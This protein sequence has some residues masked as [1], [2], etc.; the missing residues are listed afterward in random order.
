[1]ADE[2]SKETYA[3][4]LA[5]KNYIWIWIMCKQAYQEDP[6]Y[7]SKNIFQF[8]EETY[9]DCGGFD[10]D[11][12]LNFADQVKTIKHMYVFEAMQKPA[13][14][15]RSRIEKKGLIGKT[16]NFSTSCL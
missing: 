11:T 4:M 15:C 12:V 1:M 9:I 14:R 16:T 5:A 10:G 3:R 7:F 2:I 13:E 8:C 6:I